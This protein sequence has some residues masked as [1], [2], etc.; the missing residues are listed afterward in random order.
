MCAL[1]RQT[2]LGGDICDMIRHP[3]QF[4]A[5]SHCSAKPHWEVTSE[6][7]LDILFNSMHVRTAAPNPTGRWH[8]RSDSTSCAILCMFALQRQTPLEG[9]IWDLNRHPVQ[10]RVCVASQRQAPLGGFAHPWPGA[11]RAT[12]LTWRNTPPSLN[13]CEHSLCL[14]MHKSL[15]KHVHTHTHT[16]TLTCTTHTCAYTQ[17]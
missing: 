9:Y 15:C 13:W 4:Y 6:I 1:Q 14:V 10:F 3:V 16:L 5:C 12:S 11:A 2:P 17:L 7:W 8:L